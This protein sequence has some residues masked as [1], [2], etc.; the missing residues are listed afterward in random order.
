[1]CLNLNK[2]KDMQRQDLSENEIFIE[3]LEPNTGPEYDCSEKH[4]TVGELKKLAD[5][6][7]QIDDAEVINLNYNAI[8]PEGMIFV[9]EIILN[10]PKLKKIWLHCNNIGNDGIDVLLNGDPNVKEEERVQQQVANEMIRKKL[11]HISIEL[12]TNKIRDEGYLKIKDYLSPGSILSLIGGNIVYISRRL[13]EEARVSAVKCL[14]EENMKVGGVK[15]AFN[16]VPHKS[17][18]EESKE[19]SV[20][21][22]P[23]NSKTQ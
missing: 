9:R 5:K 15:A 16:S 17:E 7:K 20:A 18:H 6:F 19:Q 14:Q 12:A 13:Y 3:N 21:I 8:T 4:F 22:S 2:E 11:P 1:M 10:S 23:G